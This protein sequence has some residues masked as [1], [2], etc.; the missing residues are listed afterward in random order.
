MCV[1]CFIVCV[2]RWLPVSFGV[3]GRTAAVEDGAGGRGDGV[4]PFL[5]VEEPEE[6]D[7]EQEEVEEQPHEQE[8]VQGA[9][10]Q[11]EEVDDTIRGL[12]WEWLLEQEEGGLGIVESEFNEWVGVE[13]TLGQRSGDG[14]SDAPAEEYGRRSVGVQTRGLCSE[15]GGTEETES[16]EAAAASS[17]T[18]GHGVAASTAR[19]RPAA[20]SGAQGRNHVEGDSAVAGRG[21]TA[22]Y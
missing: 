8:E 12:Q 14:P 21:G 13:R 5:I 22:E 1:L 20:A 18:E 7:E 19:G 9:E 10:E 11:E 15:C 2:C 6:E 3:D 4:V 16:V 17:S